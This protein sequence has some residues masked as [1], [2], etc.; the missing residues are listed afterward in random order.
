MNLVQGRHRTQPYS[1]THLQRKMPRREDRK[2]TQKG[3]LKAVKDFEK[4]LSSRQCSIADLD[5][6]FAAFAKWCLHV[7]FLFESDDEQQAALQQRQALCSNAAVPVRQ[8]SPSTL[9][10]SLNG[11]ATLYKTGKGIGTVVPSE[12]TLF[13]NYIALWNAAYKRERDVLARREEVPVLSDEEL[14]QL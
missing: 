4:V 10:T 11:L 9:R 2:K 14:I 12:P 13:P 3:A 6:W 8:W 5:D 7:R 1:G